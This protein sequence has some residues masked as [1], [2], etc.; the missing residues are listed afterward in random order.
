MIKI[1]VIEY[2]TF[3]GLHTF[4]RFYFADVKI[5]FGDYE[6]A[7]LEFD[8]AESDLVVTNIEFYGSGLVDMGVIPPASAPSLAESGTGLTGTYYYKYTYID[9]IGKE[10]Q[11]STAAGL[12]VA[13]KGIQVTVA[14]STQA[15]I[16]YIKIYRLVSTVYYSCSDYI[17]ANKSG[18]YVDTKDDEDIGISYSN[19][20]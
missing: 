11:A 5:T 2:L 6:L 15:K 16:I 9:E 3:I 14:P 19:S 4:S 17:L 18:S 12:E 10:S 7:T 8:G 13:N 20:G 1:E